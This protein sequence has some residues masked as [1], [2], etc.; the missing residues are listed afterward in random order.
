MEVNVSIEQPGLEMWRYRSAIT[1]SGSSATQ[2][3]EDGYEAAAP[4]QI[5]PDA[6]LATLSAL[7]FSVQK[8]EKRAIEC[9]GA[10]VRGFK[11]R[12]W[13]ALKKAQREGRLIVFA[14]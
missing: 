11:W 5:R 4:C 1:S 12:T 10:T 8:P 2:A 14:D 13:L 3:R 7:G 9:N 6:Y